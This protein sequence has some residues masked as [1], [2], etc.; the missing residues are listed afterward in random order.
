MKLEKAAR[1]LEALGH[2]T[3]L[4]IYRTL[5]R[6]GHAGLVVGQVQE[7]RRPARLDVVTPLKRLIEQGL[8]RQERAGTSLIL[9]C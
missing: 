3:R 4:R 7:R 1:Q 5:V 6:A 2:P 9:P 8:V